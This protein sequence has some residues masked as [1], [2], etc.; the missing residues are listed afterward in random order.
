MVNFVEKNSNQSEDSEPVS[1]STATTR[2]ITSPIGMN[3]NVD[4]VFERGSVH[5]A[6]A[7]FVRGVNSIPTR[8]HIPP[9]PPLNPMYA[10]P[11]QTQRMA[12][13]VPNLNIGA[14]PGSPVP[15]GSDIGEDMNS[16]P[17]PYHRAAT[18]AIDNALSNERDRISKLEEIEAD[19]NTVDQFKAALR[20][21]R[22]HSKQLVKELAELK[23]VAVA[24]T[25][26]A[27]VNEEGRINC[28]MR[29]LDGVQKEKGRIIVELEREEEMLTNTLQK[30]LN[31]V[32][33]EKENLEQQIER[34]HMLNARLRATAINSAGAVV[35]EMDDTHSQSSRAMSMDTLDAGM[36]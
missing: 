15:V 22:H 30:K 1:I 17:S 12:P 35:E 5:H 3:P 24:S 25:L 9:S 28:L 11:H 26:E 19:Y 31:Q 16:I 14:I 13:P 23:S 8:F 4:S 36:H 27:E 2:G 32:R 10:S 18:S 6:P 33:K 29:R 20:K 21:E 7:A 34:E